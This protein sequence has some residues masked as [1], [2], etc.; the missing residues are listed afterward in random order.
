MGKGKCYSMVD[1]GQRK[2]SD[3]YETPACL[4]T[5]FLEKE[6]FLLYKDTDITIMSDKINKYMPTK[7]YSILHPARG[8]GAMEFILYKYFLDVISYDIIDGIDFLKEE[9]KFDCIIENPP[10]SLAYEFIQKAKEVARCK[11]AFLLPLSYLH[12]KKRYENIWTDKVF[13]LSKIYVFTRFPMLGLPLREDGLIE[14]GMQVYAWYVWEKEHIG[15]ATIDWLDIDKYIYR[16]G[17]K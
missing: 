16:K 2:E 1:R 11:F 15:P 7:P 17:R 8:N 10:Y 13:P 9:R 12:G 4:I 3:L 5:T 14:T 6:S